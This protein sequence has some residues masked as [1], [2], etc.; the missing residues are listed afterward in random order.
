MDEKT[1]MAS[2]SAV[3][4]ESG[5]EGAKGPQNAKRDLE[6]EFNVQRAKMK[7]LFL[8]KEEDLR[9][10]VLEKQQLDSEVLGLREELQ[11]LQTLSENQKSEIQSLQMLVSE[12]VEASSSGSEEVRR[13]R[14]R[15]VDLEQQLAQ[16]RQQQEL[17]LAPATFVRSLARKLGAEPE[18]PPPPRKAEDELLQSI[19]QPLELEIG[20]LKNKLRENDALLQD[21]LK[22]KV[23]APNTS[24]AVASGGDSKPE[25]ESRGCDMCANYE[26]Q[27]VAEQTRADHARDKA[28]KFELSLKLATEELEG[29]RSVHDETT[30]AW[31]AERTE[32]GAR[33]ADLQRALDHAKEQIAQRS[34]Q[35]DRA[36]R[37]ALHNVTA[38]TVARETLQGK[39]DELERENEMLVGRYL[40][41]AAEMESEV[42][43]L[44]DDVPA[45]QEK[46][47]Q[48]HEQL[49]VCQVGRERALEDEEELRAQLQ[50]HAAMLHRREDELAEQ[51][52]RLKDVGKELDRLQTEHE[53]MKEL[54]DK[55]RQSNDTIEK[56]LEDKKRLQ[57]EVSEVRTRVCVLQQ[58]LDNSEKV[59][60]DFVRLSQSLQVQLQRIRE[61][62]SEVRWQHDEDVSECPAC[63]TPLPT[64][65]KKIH[66][67]HCGRIFC[68]PCVSQVVASG[69]R[70]LPA[71]VCSV[72]RTLLQP[73]AA[74][75]FSTRPPNSPD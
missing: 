27:L 50:Q 67:R 47:I 56:L 63:R 66:C 2:G 10:L 51:G 33:L 35:A 37:Q 65:K 44:P 7:E 68:G 31:Q 23:A 15:N 60:Q 12:T 1:K 75:Y 5:E 61:A 46:A 48:L 53:Q 36:S 41:K 14:A 52:A 45:L 30:R 24:G 55:L 49:L 13:L 29:V 4:K 54:A 74:P 64:N 19:I 73:H 34:E 18:E 58:E 28:R 3:L 71:R 20:A 11:Q 72:C 57:N 39:L 22:S 38:L 59:Q 43:D 21:A 25:T 26:R 70:G 40:R 16:L 69:P 32:G 9:Q 6:E 42:I 17:P 62:D 8:Q